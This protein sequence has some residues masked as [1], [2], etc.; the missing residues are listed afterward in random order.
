[1]CYT[2]D[3]INIFLENISRNVIESDAEFQLY[4]AL[5]KLRESETSLE[6]FNKFPYTFH[7]S[8]NAMLYSFLGKIAKVMDPATQG[9]N[10]SNEN[11]T[12]EFLYKIFESQL[13]RKM[14]IKVIAL[15]KKMDKLNEG[16]LDIRNK[17]V[18]HLDRNTNRKD[19]LKKIERNRI[20]KILD[21]QIELLNIYKKINYE[22]SFIPYFFEFSLKRET[23]G[24]YEALKR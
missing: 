23:Q 21:I 3:E 20:R 18:A 22:N 17:D 6:V 16:I 9:R 14:S 7:F 1:M 13:S 12:F 4:C 10:G 5:L 19:L 24:I 15:M 8:T 11:S 2:I